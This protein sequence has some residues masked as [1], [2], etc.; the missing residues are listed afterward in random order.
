MKKAETEKEAG[1]GQGTSKSR[2]GRKSV[3]SQELQDDICSLLSAG[4]YIRTACGLA[5]LHYSTYY[6]WDKENNEFS[7]AIK[8]ARAQA[9]TTSILRIR[10]A[11]AGGNILSV[12]EVTYPDG[13]TEKR[14]VYQASQWQADA[15][16]L[17]RSYPNDYGKARQELALSIVKPNK[18]VEEMT[19]DEIREFIASTSG[20]D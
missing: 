17:E 9:E 7:N 4:L 18:P 13:H 2:A 8:K 6:A 11:A 3:W 19:T 14:T 5:G 1:A 16:Y 20:L 10:K 12:T 15:W